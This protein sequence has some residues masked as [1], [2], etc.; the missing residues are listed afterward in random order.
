[1]CQ[2]FQVEPGDNLYLS[3]I[4]E[5]ADGA[6]TTTTSNR[7]VYLKTGVKEGDVILSI[8]ISSCFRDDEPPGWFHQQ[9]QSSR[10]NNG[11]D[12]NI[13][14]S[15]DSNNINDGNIIYSNNNNN[16]ID[17]ELHITDYERYN[18][19]AWSTRLAASILDMELCQEKM[20]LSSPSSSA[21][22]LSDDDN[23]LLLGREIWRSTLPD[24]DILRASLPVHW[25]E[26]VLAT[27]KCTALELAVDSAYFARANAVSNLSEE[28]WEAL[29][30]FKQE[31]EDEG[32]LLERE[33]N[34][35]MD[36]ALDMETLQR[37]CHDALDI[38]SPTFY[39]WFRIAPAAISI[40]HIVSYPIFHG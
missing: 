4:Q 12:N 31:E 17:E 13:N 40:G 1:M 11:S 20:R 33:C 16:N 25:D 35:V 23:N 27:A 39:A 32:I 6:T 29:M 36:I 14:S 24:K 21:S 18:P 37:K 34:D 9:Q 3:N 5:D 2:L 28:L 15:S 30:N 38:V 19:S 7:G 26:D 22:S 8:P 10:E